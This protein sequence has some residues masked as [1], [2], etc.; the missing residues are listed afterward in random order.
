MKAQATCWLGVCAAVLV[1]GAGCGQSAS[2]TARG[3]IEEETQF[4]IQRILE[5]LAVMARFARDG[6]AVAEPAQLVQVWE[7]EAAEWGRPDYRV[8]LRASGKG[9]GQTLKLPLNQP[10]WEPAV[11]DEVFA[12]LCRQAGVDPK[13]AAAPAPPAAA[14]KSPLETLLACDVESLHRAGEQV[15]GELSAQFRNPA[16]HERAALVL[17]VFGLREASGYFY[18]V[19]PTLCRMTAHLVWARAGRGG[20]SA[21]PEGQMAEVLLYALMGNQADALARLEKIAD[22]PP[23]RPW[24]RALRAWITSDYRELDAVT[25]RTPLEEVCWFGAYA[26]SVSAHEGWEKLTP[27]RAAKRVDFCRLAQQETISVELGHQLRAFGPKLERAELARVFRLHGRPLPGLAELAPELNPE[28]GPA[29][30]AGPDGRGR[31][32]VIGWG[33]WAQYLQRHLCQSLYREHRF[34]R[35]TWGVPELAKEFAEDADRT[36]DQL[37]LYPFVRRLRA[38]TQE[39]YEQE[40]RACVPVIQK[41]PHLVPAALWNLMYFPPGRLKAYI[42][43]DLPDVST[44]HRHNPPPHTAYGAAVR[45]R[46]R[47]LGS[48]DDAKKRAETLHRMA[49]YEPELVRIFLHYKYGKSGEGQPLAVLEAAYGPLLEYSVPALETVARRVRQDPDAYE[50]LMARAAAHNARHYLTLGRYFAERNDEARAL[51]YYELGVE[52]CTDAV[53]VANSSGWLVRYYF[54]HQRLDEARKLADFAAGVYSSVG[55]KTKGDLLYWLK[56]YPESFEYYRRIEERYDQKQAIFNWWLAYREETGRTDFD[57]EMDKRLDW[58]FPQGRQN[59]TLA[60]LKEPP[61]SGVEVQEENDQTQAA[62]LKKGDV[63][64]ALGGQRVDNL[65]QYLYLRVRQAEDTLRLVVWD[66]AAYREVTASP[67]QRRFGVPFGT[68]KRE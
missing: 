29:I 64:V 6:R 39:T 62:G 27:E 9:R 48:R 25:E 28:P 24:R 5:D 8:R 59:V 55:L 34:L 11:Y 35:R 58:L 31:V 3:T 12:V 57:A 44:W 65:E 7:G 40:N 26:Q 17:G 19:R 13:A 45:F 41:T 53:A 18:D 21:G 33:H 60:A 63:I 22:T 49:P 67:P 15:A 47:S 16:A 38:V 52:R 2:G 54:Q 4:I 20:A 42:P 56:Q 36:F 32:Q 43:P 37:R 30:E 68:Y 1:L 50:Q 46:H 14:E 66:G 10:V 23:T 51:K 61:G